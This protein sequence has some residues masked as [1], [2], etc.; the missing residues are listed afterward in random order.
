MCSLQADNENSDSTTFYGHTGR[1]V[2]L[3]VHT[4]DGFDDPNGTYV[5]VIEEN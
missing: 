2:Y 5:I 3:D 1:P 4:H